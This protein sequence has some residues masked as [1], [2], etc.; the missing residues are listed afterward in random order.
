[1][2]DPKSCV[3]LVSELGKK[4]SPERLQSLRAG[5]KPAPHPGEGIGTGSDVV[6][7]TILLTGKSRKLNGCATLLREVHLMGSKNNEQTSKAAATAASKVLRDPN[8]SKA[9][10]SAAASALTQRPNKK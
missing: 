10:K 6:V 8:S 7:R 5:L 1:L 4:K 2:K 9:A 3:I